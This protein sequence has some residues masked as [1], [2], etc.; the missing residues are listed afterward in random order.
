MKR[1][2]FSGSFGVRERNI[3]CRDRKGRV[4]SSAVDR[5]RIERSGAIDREDQLL[6]A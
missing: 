3:E 1:G 5:G 2:G 6:P 4:G